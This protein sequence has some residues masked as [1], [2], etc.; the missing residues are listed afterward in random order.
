[1]ASMQD[2]LEHLVN[3]DG[4]KRMTALEALSHPWVYGGLNSVKPLQGLCEKLEKYK[5]LKMI[6]N[7]MD[8]VNSSTYD[9]IFAKYHEDSKEFISSPISCIEP[10]RRPKVA[11]SVIVTAES[12]FYYRF[13]VQANRPPTTYDYNSSSVCR[14]LRAM[15][16]T[17][18]VTV[19]EDAVRCQT[20][21]SSVFMYNE[22]IPSLWKLLNIPIV[23]DYEEWRN[24]IMAA[25]LAIKQAREAK[26]EKERALLLAA[27]MAEEEKENGEEDED[28]DYKYNESEVFSGISDQS[29]GTMLAEPYQSSRSSSK[30]SNPFSEL[31]KNVE[32]SLI[33]S[34]WPS[35]L[36]YS[37]YTDH[38]EKV[39]LTIPPIFT[40]EDLESAEVRLEDLY[41]NKRLS[42][43]EPDVQMIG[44]LLVAKPK[45]KFQKRKSTFD[46]MLMVDH[47]EYFQR[48]YTPQQ[49]TN[50]VIKEL[51]QTCQCLYDLYRYRPPFH[52]TQL[53]VDQF[54]IEQQGRPGEYL[55][56][57]EDYDPEHA[58]DQH[59]MLCRGGVSIKKETP[60]WLLDVENQVPYLIPI[61]KFN[62]II[63]NGIP[64]PDT[65]IQTP[66]EPLPMTEFTVYSLL[67]DPMFSR[68]NSF[69]NSRPPEILTATYYV[70]FNINPRHYRD[71]HCPKEENLAKKCPYKKM[72]IER[73]DIIKRTLRT[74]DIKNK[75]SAGFLRKLTATTMNLTGLDELKLRQAAEGIDDDADEFVNAGDMESDGGEKCRMILGW[76]NNLEG[77]EIAKTRNEELDDDCI[78]L[79]GRPCLMDMFDSVGRFCAL[80]KRGSTRLCCQN[81]YAIWRKM[82]RDEEK[83]AAS[84]TL[85][86]AK[87]DYIP[88]LTLDKL[89]AK[90]KFAKQNLSVG[91]LVVNITEKPDLRSRFKNASVGKL[92][93]EKKEDDVS[94]K[95]SLPVTIENELQ[96][97]LQ[98]L[99][100]LKWLK[101]EH[102]QEHPQSQ[103][104]Q[105]FNWTNFVYPEEKG[106]PLVWSFEVFM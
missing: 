11:R 34:M 67:E 84:A 27:E 94:V 97:K 39:D 66:P 82:D 37:N 47:P 20:H 62:S 75:N 61:T 6:R 28:E 41:I 79:T 72:V 10:L 95:H 76:L 51:V 69:P 90:N 17:P 89:E 45:K 103:Q 87:V 105:N 104:C 46:F 81:L 33:Y 43:F 93:E 21:Y 38:E 16:K 32:E 59:Y 22:Y 98:L 102:L 24:R 70:P 88:N 30:D 92:T 18:E 64:V 57:V 5:K 85:P 50:A 15:Y 1:M 44:E 91:Q 80:S 35:H 68:F 31:D 53:G 12:D 78:H 86:F 13:G 99:K 96:K 40:E 3:L 23:A 100:E 60:P 101:N 42:E 52:P 49:F 56:N 63:K 8:V 58:N 106:E 36:K 9:A 2:F 77:E 7:K 83:T 14:V 71:C 65:C 54:T 19:Y 74:A 4:A 73:M 48:L 25:L 29:T 55:P 26:K